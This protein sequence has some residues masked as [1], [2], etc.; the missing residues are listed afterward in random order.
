M[1]TG[2]GHTQLCLP[3]RFYLD[4]LNTER[5]LELSGRSGDIGTLREFSVDVGTIRMCGL[6]SGSRWDSCLIGEMRVTYPALFNR[7]EIQRNTMS[8]FRDVNL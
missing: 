3:K 5:I 8:S 7:R 6:Y 2:C 4:S 1:L